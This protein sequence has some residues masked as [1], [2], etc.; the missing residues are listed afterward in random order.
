MV[1]NLKIKK[2]NPLVDLDKNGQIDVVDITIVA[3]DYGRAAD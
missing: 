3:R 1:A 2:W